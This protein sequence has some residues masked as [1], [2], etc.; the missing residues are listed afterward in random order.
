MQR[1]PKDVAGLFAARSESLRRVPIRTRES[2]STLSA[3][4]LELVCNEGRGAVVLVEAGAQAH[5]RGE[6]VLLGAAQDR[7][8]EI[9]AALTAQDEAPHAETPQLG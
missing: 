5:A 9:Y 2:G 3:W 1:E 4:R 7:L 8:R 6:G